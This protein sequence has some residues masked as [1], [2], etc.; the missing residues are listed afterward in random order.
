M[1][2]DIIS[3][4]KRSFI[5]FIEPKRLTT[6]QKLPVVILKQFNTFLILSRTVFSLQKK[7]MKTKISIRIF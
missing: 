4:L 5:N 3:E 7:T 1:R 2:K 6:L